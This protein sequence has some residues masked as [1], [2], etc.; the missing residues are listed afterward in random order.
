MAVVVRL[1][2]Y[3]AYRYIGC[4][5]DQSDW[6]GPSSLV[7][8]MPDSESRGRR[9]KSRSGHSAE[10]L[11]LLLLHLVPGARMTTVRAQG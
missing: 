1:A 9:F 5:T 8:M 10:V 2:K 6:S 3:N 4:I 7:V 11:F